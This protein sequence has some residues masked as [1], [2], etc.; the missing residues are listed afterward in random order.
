MLIIG[1]RGAPSLNDENTVDSFKSAL[2][3]NVDG[4]ELDVQLT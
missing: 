4:I 2:S 3:C 1:H